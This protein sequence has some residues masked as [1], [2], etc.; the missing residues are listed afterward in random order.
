MLTTTTKFFKISLLIIL[1]FWASFGSAQKYKDM[2]DDV[3]YN[4]YDVIEEGKA[5]FKNRDKHINS[6]KRANE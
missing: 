2:M 6:I 3:K 4:V 1:C 5:Y